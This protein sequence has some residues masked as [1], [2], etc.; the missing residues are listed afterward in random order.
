MKIV[1]RLG[2]DHIKRGDAIFSPMKLLTFPQMAADMYSTN[3][4]DMLSCSLVRLTA[5]LLFNSPY[6]DSLPLNTNKGNGS[7][8]FKT[9]KIILVYTQR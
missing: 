9:Y 1:C 3:L 2:D 7:V 8:R 4:E 5:Y 6:S